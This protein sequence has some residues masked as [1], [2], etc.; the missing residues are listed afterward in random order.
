MLTAGL[1][2]CKKS[3]DTCWENTD[4]LAVR[5]GYGVFKDIGPLELIGCFTCGGCPGKKIVERANLLVKAGADII[6]LSS[7]MQNTGDGSAC[8]YYESIREALGKQLKSV[9]IVD[10]LT[11]RGM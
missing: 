8:P 10:P 7:S 2:G 6:A 3:R 4:L 11:S 9:I 5:Q 1:I